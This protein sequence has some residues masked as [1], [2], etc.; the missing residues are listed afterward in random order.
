MIAGEIRVFRK[1][2]AEKDSPEKDSF[3]IRQTHG[4]TILGSHVAI[5]EEIRC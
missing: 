1:I 3:G 5:S 4:P 2:G